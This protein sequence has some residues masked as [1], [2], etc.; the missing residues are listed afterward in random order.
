MSWSPSPSQ[1]NIQT[2]DGK[3]K[4]DPWRQTWRLPNQKRVDGPRPGTRPPGKTYVYERGRVREQ[5]RGK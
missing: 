2:H 1:R 3:A 5:R 4:W